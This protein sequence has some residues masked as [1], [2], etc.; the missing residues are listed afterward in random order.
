[1]RRAMLWRPVTND[2]CLSVLICLA[3]GI[4]VTGVCLIAACFFSYLNSMYDAACL[5]GFGAIILG[6]IWV[7]GMGVA[8]R[9]FRAH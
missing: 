1:M 2:I 5:T 7:G 8:S 4:M 3:Y 9:R 6:S